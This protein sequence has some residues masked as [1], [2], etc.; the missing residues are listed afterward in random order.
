MNEILPG[1]VLQ[2]LDQRHEELLAELDLLNQRLESALST[3]TQP[4]H[5]DE[6]APQD[7]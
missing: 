6:A 1:D 3:F 4:T 2:Q 5:S 7:T